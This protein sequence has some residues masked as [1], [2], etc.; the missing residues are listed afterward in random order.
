MVLPIGRVQINSQY[1]DQVRFLVVWQDFTV[2]YNN[3]KLGDQRITL[4]WSLA[5][6]IHDPYR[7]REVSKTI[8]VVKFEIF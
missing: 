5:I 7:K 4:K 1:K 6:T 8:Y 3:P 2:R